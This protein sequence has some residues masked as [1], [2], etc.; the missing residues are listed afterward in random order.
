MAIGPF[1]KV[2]KPYTGPADNWERIFGKQPL[3]NE[4]EPQP[5]EDRFK[6]TDKPVRYVKDRPAV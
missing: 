1:A 6:T 3:P 4:R 2:F 5:T